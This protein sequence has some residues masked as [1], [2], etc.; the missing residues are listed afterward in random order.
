M[1]AKR[2]SDTHSHGKVYIKSEYITCAVVQEKQEK[3]EAVPLDGPFM[4]HMYAQRATTLPKNMVA[5]K[6]THFGLQLE[7]STGVD[8]LCIH[9]SLG[10]H[11]S[12][13]CK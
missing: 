7:S 9:R 11:K 4:L 8:R 12:Y 13:S 3:S 6:D 1:H 10:V 5:N 2:Y